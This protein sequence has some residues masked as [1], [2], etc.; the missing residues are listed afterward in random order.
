MGRAWKLDLKH[1]FDLCVSIAVEADTFSEHGSRLLTGYESAFDSQ[2]TIGYAFSA[3]IIDFLVP[4]ALFALILIVQNLHPSLL[5][6][7]QTNLL[8]RAEL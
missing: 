4:D 6:S 7:K 5:W 3:V 2:A 1:S 8:A